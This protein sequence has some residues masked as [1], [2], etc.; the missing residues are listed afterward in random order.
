LTDL[1]NSSGL[2]VGNRYVLNDYKTI[3]QINGTNSSDRTEIHTI[4]GSSGAYSQFD[5]VPDTIAADGDTF[6]VFTH[7]VV[8]VLLVA[9]LISLITLTLVIY[10]FHLD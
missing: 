4:I 3:Y 1:V 9:M 5:N 10:H 6:Y 8:R 7:L 2:T